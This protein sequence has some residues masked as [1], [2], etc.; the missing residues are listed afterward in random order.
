MKF[1]VVVASSFYAQAQSCP[2]TITDV[3]N[4]EH[5]LFVLF[6]NSGSATLT[7]Y[8]FGLIFIDVTGRQHPFPLR[9]K[10]SKAVEPGAQHTVSL[11]SREALQFLYPEA[12]AYL[13][14]ARFSDGTTW[15]DDGSHACGF[16]SW[17]E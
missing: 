13:L 6:E 17:Q 1:T 12:N 4:I 9:I 5:T 8:Q 15:T 14:E 3:R 16:T 11:S 10:G 7:E 2:V